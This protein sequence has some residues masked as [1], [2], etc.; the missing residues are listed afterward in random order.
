MISK[1]SRRLAE[2]AH[3]LSDQMNQLVT[4]LNR[5]NK[6][7]RELDIEETAERVGH[8][9]HR[10]DELGVSLKTVNFSERKTFPTLLRN[11][12]YY[13]LMLRHLAE[14]LDDICAGIE[15]GTRLEDERMIMR[16]AETA[17]IFDRIL[18][19]MGRYLNRM[20]RRQARVGS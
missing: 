10:L 9:I 1:S 2:K 12:E 5:K 17:S 20:N 15:H 4:K 7:E 8:V 18:P 13:N 14:D 6:R 3:R 11:L 16:L 19:E